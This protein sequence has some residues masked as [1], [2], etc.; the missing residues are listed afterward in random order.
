MP[1]TDIYEIMRIIV[2]QQRRPPPAAPPIDH[3]AGSATDTG[4]TGNRI[5]FTWGPATPASSARTTV[6]RLVRLPGNNY[7]TSASALQS[8]TATAPLSRS[9]GAYCTVSANVL[10]VQ[11]IPTFNSRQQRLLFSILRSPD[12]W[13]LHSANESPM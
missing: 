2:R 13:R 7:G 10:A 4:H 5:T 3:P 11:H 9:H 12:G 6:D 8:I 1:P